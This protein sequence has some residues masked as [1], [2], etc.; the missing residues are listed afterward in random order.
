[1]LFYFSCVVAACSVSGVQATWKRVRAQVVPTTVHVSIGV[2]SMHK[3]TVY[4]LMLG[5][6]IH[7]LLL[8]ELRILSQRYTV[9]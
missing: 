9:P 6:S 2:R 1:M 8:L 7:G 3:Y 4:I 5:W